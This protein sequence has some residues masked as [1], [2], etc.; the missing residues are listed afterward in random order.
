MVGALGEVGEL[1]CRELGRRFQ[2]RLIIFSRRSAEAA[3]KALARI[4]AAGAAV[5]YCSVDALDAPAL[6]REMRIL[7]ERGEV[8]HGVIHSARRVLDAPIVRK[9]SRD[10]I[11][12][13]AAKVQG[14]MNI[15]ALTADDPLEFFIAFSSV[16][17]LGIKGSPDY[18]YSSAF[19]NALARRRNVRS[20]QAERSVRFRAFCWGQFERDGGVH[21][22]RLPAR[23]AEL[24]GLGIEA[25]DV[26]SSIA[27]ME[28]G[29]CQS[30]SVI[31][32]VAVR[33]RAKLR[34]AMGF[35]Q[36]R[37]HTT[38]EIFDEIGIFERGE[39][40]DGRFA[41]FLKTL[42]PEDYTETV[43]AR[44]I[45]A[46]RRSERGGRI[47]THLDSTD[48]S[49]LSPVPLRIAEHLGKVLK[50]S[51]ETLDHAKPFQEYGLDSITAMQL[52]SRLEKEFQISI[53]PHWLIE[54]P[55]IASFSGKIIRELRHQDTP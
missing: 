23:I 5:V 40:G 17:S 35:D 24:N 47:E 54:Y 41:E 50:I 26:A 46:L 25:I 12:V 19:Q 48:G 7:K 10:F 31:G 28:A 20:A 32:F 30:S 16:A 6:K 51:Q 53:Q 42:N 27:A 37:G 21:P 34:E 45:A 36:G 3:R 33:D 14:T 49:K 8:I 1:I 44:V 29:L 43:R 18:A 55:C 15:E 38:Q 9:S 2:S 11:A 39:S 4:E 13:M 22:D 52:S